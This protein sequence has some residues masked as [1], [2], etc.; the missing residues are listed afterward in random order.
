MQSLLPQRPEYFFEILQRLRQP[1]AATFVERRGETSRVIA[2]GPCETPAFRLD[3]RDPNVNTP[4]SRL[5]GTCAGCTE[6]TF[7]IGPLQFGGENTQATATAAISVFYA[8]PASRV[9]RLNYSFSVDERLLGRIRLNTII[10]LNR[11]FTT[12]E[13]RDFSATVNIRRLVRIFDGNQMALSI[14]EEILSESSSGN[15]P[16]DGNFDSAFLGVERIFNIDVPSTSFPL[17]TAEFAVSGDND[18]I[19]R[20]DYV[21][22]AR[23]KGKTNLVTFTGEFGQNQFVVRNRDV[24]LQARV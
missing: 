17:L 7:G 18:L 6:N 20:F 22:D 21:F 11:P 19:I 15:S 9:H 2:P 23:A 13:E 1:F 12:T 4:A 8:V 5:V 10:T 14:D 16:A 3:I 24:I